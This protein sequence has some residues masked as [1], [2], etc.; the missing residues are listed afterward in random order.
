[1]NGLNRN[2]GFIPVRVIHHHPLQRIQF[3]ADFEK[4]FVDRELGCSSGRRNG[5]YR[6]GGVS[7]V[8]GDLAI[9]GP[10]EGAGILVVTGK[11]LVTGSFRSYSLCWQDRF[12][13]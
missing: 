2:E 13:F 1:L 3:R 11:L 8:D 5:H 12:R 7:L 9:N 4:V 10:I 6:I